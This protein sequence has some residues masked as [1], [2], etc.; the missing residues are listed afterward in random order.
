MEDNNMTIASEPVVAHPITSYN[1]VMTYLHSIRISHEDKEKVARRLTVE[2]A[3]QYL[4]KAFDR[5]DHLSQLPCPQRFS[6]FAIQEA[7]SF[8]KRW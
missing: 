3:G 4:T 8:N 6:G 1:D 7:L 5:L 2:V